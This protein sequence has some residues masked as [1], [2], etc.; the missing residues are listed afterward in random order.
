[1]SQIYHI[2]KEQCAFT[3]DPTLPPVLRVAAPCT[4][5]FETD[6]EGYRRLYQGESIQQIG[7]QNLNKVSGPIFIENAEPGDAIKIEVLDIAVRSAWT[8][9]I[10]G[11]G[12][13]G[14]QTQEHHIRPLPLE[15]GYARIN[16]TL[17]VRLEPMIGCIGLAPAEGSSSTVSPVFPWGGN[18][19][20]RELSP[21][22]VLYLPVQVS[23][24]LLSVGDLHA[25]MGSGEPTWVSLESAGEATLRIS[26]EKGMALKSPRLRVG[27]STMVVGMGKTIPEAVLSAFE[28]AFDIL[29][30]DFGLEPFDAYA[31]ASARV[32][33]RFAGPAGYNVL[34]VIPDIEE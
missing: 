12:A 9:W 26:L 6:D 15:D 24:G 17:R 25:A 8:V 2:S 18:M 4:I 19:D 5:A 28:Q 31:Y 27:N 14:K 21:G 29:T 1:M 13:L 11:F 16:E 3:L 7:S 20:L 33:L 30:H 10:P 34:A 22:A 32:G 23:G